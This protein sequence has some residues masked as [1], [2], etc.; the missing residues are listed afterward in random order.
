MNVIFFIFL[1]L[2]LIVIQTVILPSFSFFAQSF[3][4]LIIAV[5]FLSLISTH[6]STIF[7]IIIIGCIMDSMSGVPFCH[8]IFSYLWIYIIVFLAKQLLFKQSVIFLLIISMISILIQHGLLLFSVLITRGDH[9]ILNLNLGLMIRQIFWGLVLIPP[10]IWLV[11]VFWQNWKFVTK[12]WQK[13][14]AKG[15]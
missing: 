1:T 5:L 15:L 12:S 14:I 11:N 9:M 2:F 8:H 6:Y 10:A 7:V 3:D 13:K 4:L